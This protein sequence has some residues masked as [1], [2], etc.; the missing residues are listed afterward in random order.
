MVAQRVC[1]SISFHVAA[2]SL[3]KKGDGRNKLIKGQREGTKK[4][5]WEDAKTDTFSLGRLGASY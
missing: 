2:P 1:E 3:T 4:R 5:V